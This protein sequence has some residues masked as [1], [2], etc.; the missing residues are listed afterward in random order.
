VL[1][2]KSLEKLSITELK[3]LLQEKQE[4]KK[5]FMSMN[6]TNR[7][8]GKINTIENQIALIKENITAS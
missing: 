6:K 2:K 5:Y 1:V 4:E 8:S 7:Y 3:L